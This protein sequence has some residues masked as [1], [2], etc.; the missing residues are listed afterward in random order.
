MDEENKKKYQKKMDASRIHLRLNAREKSVLEN[1]MK[2][3]GW[4]NMSGYIRCKLFGIEP[5]REVQK[6]ISSKDPWAIA[7]LLRNMVF[8]LTEN[9]L[10]VKFRYNKDMAQLYREEGADVKEWARATNKWYAALTK[11][12]EL[13]LGTIADI[14]K[15][16]GLTSYFERPSDTMQADFDETDP[17]KLD[18]LAEQLHKERVA[19]GGPDT[20]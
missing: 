9:Y 4:E 19:Y 1:K 12:T 18:A 20:F 15:T 3:E 17:D 13:A 5:D 14:A 2:E 16:L 7:N 10:Y 11:K 8:E 6:L